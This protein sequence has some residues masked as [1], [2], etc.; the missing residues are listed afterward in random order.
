MIASIV[1]VSRSE[2]SMA[3]PQNN[4]GGPKHNHLL[5]LKVNWNLMV[6]FYLVIFH[7]LYV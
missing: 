3:D 1:L 5:S 7:F 2:S 6:E 4:P